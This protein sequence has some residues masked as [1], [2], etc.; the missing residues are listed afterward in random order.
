[1]SPIIIYDKQSILNPE[2]IEFEGA[3][4]SLNLICTASILTRSTYFSVIILSF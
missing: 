2:G 4:K 1:M 3:G